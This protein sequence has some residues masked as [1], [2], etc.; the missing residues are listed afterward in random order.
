MKKRFFSCIGGGNA[1]ITSHI[2]EFNLIRLF[3]NLAPWGEKKFVSELKRT[4]KFQRGVNNILDCHANQT[5][6]LSK[7]YSFV[8]GDYERSTAR[9]DVKRHTEDNSPKYRMV[10]N[11]VGLESPTHR[12][13]CGE[14]RKIVI[15]R[16]DKRRSNRKNY[17]FCRSD[18]LIRQRNKVARLRNKCA[19][20]DYGY[21]VSVSCGLNPS[22]AFQAPSPQVARGKIKSVEDMKG[23]IFSNMVNSLFTTHHSLKQPGATHVALCDSVG[24]Y[25]RHWCGAFT[26]AEVLITLGIIGVVA[27]MTMP[28]LINN[29]N[30]KH[31]IAGYKK[32]YSE[33]SQIHQL[34]NSETGGSYMVECGDFDDVCLKN[35]FAEKVKVIESCKGDIPNKCQGKSTFLDGSTW[36]QASGRVNINDNQWPSIVTASGYSVKFRFHGN[37]CSENID[38]FSGKLT[39]CGWMQVDVNGLK[40]P[41]VVG[42]DIYLINIYKN[43]LVPF[44]LN[45]ADEETLKE[46]CL[47][48]IGVGCST[49]Y[50]YE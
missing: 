3:N 2:K 49:I 18:L 11:D 9:N 35:L 16:S 36:N 37:D 17:N 12:N 14:Y 50:L 21:H 20:T 25:F 40:K 4:Y 33:L 28:T 45:N 48:G 41:N 24:S 26:L 19:M 44:S 30:K 5:R 42:K 31:W 1:R 22:P 15:T 38:G 39:T 34:L 32:A 8:A 13:N 27:A 6:I 47:H 46:D 43:K 7:E 23:N 29:I 10:C